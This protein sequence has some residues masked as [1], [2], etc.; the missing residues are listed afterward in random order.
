[1][2]LHREVPGMSYCGYCYHSSDRHVPPDIASRT[3]ICLDCP[4]G[5]MKRVGKIS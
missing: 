4:I 5:D 2:G 3:V 1:M